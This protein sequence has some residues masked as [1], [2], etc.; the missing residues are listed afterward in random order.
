MSIKDKRF[1]IWE[2]MML[3]CGFLSAWL[4]ALNF[5]ISLKQIPATVVAYVISCLTGGGIAWL[6]YKGYSGWKRAGYT[7]LFA[8]FAYGVIEATVHILFPNPYDVRQSLFADALLYWCLASLLP[9]LLFSFSAKF[10]F[11]SGKREK[12]EDEIVGE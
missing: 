1:G 6:V 11:R 12:S 9:V 8:T 7:F 10:F 3:L 5:G 2:G 4:Y